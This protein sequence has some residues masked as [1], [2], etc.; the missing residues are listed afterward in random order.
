[1]KVFLNKKKIFYNLLKG[2]SKIKTYTKIKYF[3]KKKILFMLLKLID[4]KSINWDYKLEAVEF[5]FL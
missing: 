2:L 5:L 1:M 4:I 3:D